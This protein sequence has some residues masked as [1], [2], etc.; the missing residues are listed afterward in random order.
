MA[1]ASYTAFLEQ[2]QIGS[3]NF[4]AVKCE[5]CQRVTEGERRPIIIFN[6][7]NGRVVDIDYQNPEL[8]QEPLPISSSVHAD[9]AKEDR[10]L[11]RVGRP[12]LGVVAKE[13]TL[14]PRHWE[15][16]AAQQGGASVTLRKLVEEARRK[17]P[18]AEI[19]QQ[20]RDACYRIINALAGNEAASEDAL[21]AL[22]ADDQQ[23]FAEIIALW[24]QDV[25]RYVNKMSRSAFS[26][27]DA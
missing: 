10:Q 6:D 5:A 23:T 25:S 11:R 9:E 8:S 3:G 21:R 19:M 7:A 24:P 26:A 27:Q 2:K 15:W 13:V 1:P 14:L 22:Y 18:D 4:E 16:L 17:N 20:S 12:K